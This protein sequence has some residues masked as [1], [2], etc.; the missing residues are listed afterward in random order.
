MKELLICNNYSLTEFTVDVQRQNWNTLGLQHVQTG[1]VVTIVSGT[2][3]NRYRVQSNDGLAMALVVQQLVNRLKDKATGNFTT[4]IAQNH[5]QLV[6]S[7]MEAHFRSRQET[8]KITVK[9]FAE[10]SH[11]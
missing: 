2:T 1:S 8:D 6:Q 7:Q 10:I 11:L 4:T 5:I 3:S 9:L